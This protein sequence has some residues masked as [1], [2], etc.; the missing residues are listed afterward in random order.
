MTTI[1]GSINLANEEKPSSTVGN[2]IISAIG[3]V[4]TIGFWYL[5]SKVAVT[6]NSSS[7]AGDAACNLACIKLSIALLGGGIIFEFWSDGWWIDSGV[8]ILLSIFFFKEGYEMLKWGC[9]KKFDG[10][11]GDCK[12]EVEKNKSYSC[13]SSK[14]TKCNEG[15]CN[16]EK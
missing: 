12:G 5:K 2:I 11:C 16:E 9:S 15:K 13:P 7:I 4:F 10:G 6:L 1:V 14:G 8:A 3:L